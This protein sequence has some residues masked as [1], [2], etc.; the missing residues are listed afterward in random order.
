MKTSRE[1][2]DA[3]TRLSPHPA[4]NETFDINLPCLYEF[5]EDERFIYPMSFQFT[6]MVNFLYFLYLKLGNPNS[7]IHSQ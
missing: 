2:Y 5:M 4:S 1:A 3:V 7:K 6:R